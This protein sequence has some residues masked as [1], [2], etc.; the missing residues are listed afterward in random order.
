MV[1]RDRVDVPSKCTI[2]ETTE[3]VGQS[4]GQK[5]S[6]AGGSQEGKNNT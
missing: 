3:W 1:W 5:K 2:V 4:V 6:V